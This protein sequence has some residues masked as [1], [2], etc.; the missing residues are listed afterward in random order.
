M[1]ELDKQSNKKI[2]AIPVA[3]ET[4]IVKNPYRASAYEWSD[5]L[6]EKIYD[7]IKKCD[8]C[9][10][11]IAANLG[12]KAEN[13]KNVKDHVFYNEQDLNHYDPDQIEHKRFDVTLSQALALKRLEVGT[14]TQDDV[15]WIKHECAEW[16]HEVKYG[17]G[18]SEAH[19]CAQ[20]HYDG[21]PWEND[22]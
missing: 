14:Y 19:D 5:K 22:W 20:S 12:F 4:Y 18:Y 8:N 15:T 10:Y 13:I 3:G 17:S 16:H 6:A 1:C 7:L 11:N 2:I 21:S 9:V